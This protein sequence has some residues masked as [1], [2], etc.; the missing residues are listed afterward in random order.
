MNV[1]LYT[2]YLKALIAPKMPAAL[3]SGLHDQRSAVVTPIAQM[4]QICRVVWKS[5]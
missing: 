3:S 5:Q 4:A 2:T 1:K